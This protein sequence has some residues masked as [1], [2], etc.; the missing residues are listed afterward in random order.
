MVYVPNGLHFKTK[1]HFLFIVRWGV[2][3]QPWML[4]TTLPES[5]CRQKNVIKVA[6]FVLDEENTDWSPQTNYHRAHCDAWAPN[7]ASV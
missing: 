7:L 4:P 5:V 2:F 6:T 3:L 1:T